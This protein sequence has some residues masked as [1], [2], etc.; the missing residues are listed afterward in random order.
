M[1]NQTLKLIILVVTGICAGASIAQQNV[2]LEQIRWKSESQVRSLLGEPASIH[3]PIGTHASYTLWKYEGF[4]IAF[5]N[6]RAFHLFDQD[7]LRKIELI[8]SRDD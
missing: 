8:E 2:D 1:I 5:A 6:Q 4:T 7:S 3:G